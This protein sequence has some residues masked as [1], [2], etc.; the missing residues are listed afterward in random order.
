M[1][2]P[3]LD[4]TQY[5]REHRNEPPINWVL[6]KLEMIIQGTELPTTRK[7]LDLTFQYMLKHSKDKYLFSAVSHLMHTKEAIY[8]AYPNPYEK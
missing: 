8:N 4:T 7:H 2:I 1:P 6:N 3:S 5:L